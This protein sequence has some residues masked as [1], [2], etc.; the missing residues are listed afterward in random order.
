[1][2]GTPCSISAIPEERGNV[3]LAEFYRFP[4]GCTGDFPPESADF[5]GGWA[6][7][8]KCPR[9]AMVGWLRHAE[10]R[11]EVTGAESIA[12]VQCV[13]CTGRTA[14]A[15]AC[16][17]AT[18]LRY[19]IGRGLTEGRQFSSQVTNQGLYGMAAAE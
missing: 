12:K 19:R 10:V 4:P 11:V 3:A 15:I 14:I 13:A 8:R 2:D 7:L 1:M 16:Q 5:E 18:S 9:K 17:V 6:T